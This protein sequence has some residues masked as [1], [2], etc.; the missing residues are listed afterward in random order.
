MIG[1]IL[2]GRFLLE[3][4]LGRGGMGAVYRARDQILQRTVAIKVLKEISGD[5]VGK[6]LRLEAQILARLVHDHVVRLYDFGEDRGISYF[7]MEEVDG[8]SF[9]KRWRKL[10]LPER[11]R[12]LAQVAEALDYAHHQGVIHRDVKP[13]NI[14]LTS[15]DQAKLSDFGLS[16]LVGEVQETGLVR[17]TPQYMSPEQA[18]GHPLDHRA[19]LYALGV[20]LYECATGSPPFQGAMLS[21]MAQHIH[22]PPEPPRARNPALSEDLERLILQAMAKDPQARPASGAEVA[23]RLRKLVA[24]ERVFAAA[25][26]GAGPAAETPPPAAVPP[27]AAPARKLG[28]ARELLDAVEADPIALTPE[29]RYLC[30]HYLAYLLG[31]TRR[32]GFL[33]RRPLDPLNA[34]RGRLLLAMT[35]LAMVGAEAETIARAAELFD[36][37]IDVRPS[38]SPIVVVKYLAARDTPAKRQRFRQIRR[39]LQQASTYATRYLTDARGVLNPGLMPQRLGD[40]KRLAPARTEVDDQLV[41]R[42]NRVAEVW[43]SNPEF[44]EAVLRYATRSAWRDPASIHLWPEVVYPL[45]ERARWQRRLRSTP[46]A[47]WDALCGHLHLPDAGL[48]LDREIQRAVPEPVAQVLDVSL[49]AFEE[50]PVLE[51]GSSEAADPESRRL[52]PPSGIRPESFEDLDVV[53]PERTLVRLASPDPFRQTLG[54]LR[55]LWREG[56]AALRT[57]AE[58]RSAQ[59]APAIGPYRLAVIASIRSRAAG[60]VAIQG[61]PNKQIELIVPSFARGGPDA[62]PILAIWLY[63]NQSLVIAY[64]DNLGHQRYVLW[65]AAAGQQ[66]NFGA[67]ADLSR[68]LLQLGLEVPDDLDRALSKAFR[69]K[70]PV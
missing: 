56:L 54:E 21:L 33:R 38:L 66:T 18:Q 20:I 41:Q 45:I 39:A 13:A 16:M 44:R 3:M 14:L 47:L 49:Q 8:T 4:E 17:G 53:E 7:I 63:A 48:R 29:E 64:L 24:G 58:A 28:S 25:V 2:N 46:E 67:V 6:K 57:P 23:Q 52:V 36:R 35:Y 5:E 65:D 31:G 10:P 32:R 51:V 40:L 69:P 62:R 70:N 42:W 34:D 22:T 59:P 27:A 37:Q 26:A 1:A 60:Q 19:D 50:E 12:I 55:A 68:T 15:S 9:Q 61:M 30:G 11:L 43:R